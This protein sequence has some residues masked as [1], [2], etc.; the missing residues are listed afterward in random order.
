MNEWRKSEENSR[1]GWEKCTKKQVCL[2]S[3]PEYF[4]FKSKHGN[5]VQKLEYLVTNGMN[6]LCDIITALLIQTTTTTK[7][8]N[9]LNSNN[10]NNNTIIIIIIKILI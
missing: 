8:K 5:N 7:Q 2:N 3:K 4:S 9:T 6:C 10:R 1:V